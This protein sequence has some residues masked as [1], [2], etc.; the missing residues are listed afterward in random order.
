VL[1]RD[2]TLTRSS[3]R[4]AWLG[5]TLGLM[6]LGSNILMTLIAWLTVGLY[7]AA[8]LLWRAW[9]LMR[10]GREATGRWREVAELLGLPLLTGV[11][12]LGVGAVQLLPTVELAGQM[13]RVAADYDRYVSL[14]R[15]RPGDLRAILLPETIATDGTLNNRLW[16]VGW[17]PLALAPLALRRREGRWWLLVAAGLALYVLGTPLTWLG[18]HTVP[19]LDYFRPL[20]RMLFVWALALAICAALGYEVLRRWIDVRRPGW[21]RWMPL[22][23]VAIIAL[24]AAQLI[25]YGRAINPPFQPR[26][27]DELYPRTPLTTLLAAEGTEARIEPAS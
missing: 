7:Y 9:P 19:G 22:G 14:W 24:T 17:L 1:A 2:T 3:G 25:G 11:V 5:A 13:A 26:T 6:I 10:S 21:R 4:A 8:L 23:G 27:A 20:G 15:V 18:V 16:F 12:G